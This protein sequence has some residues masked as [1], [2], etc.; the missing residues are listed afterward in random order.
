M[1]GDL[2]GIVKIVVFYN[3]KVCMCKIDLNDLN[4]I[5]F[6]CALM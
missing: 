5:K 3:K 1:K 4:L 2:Q 6:V